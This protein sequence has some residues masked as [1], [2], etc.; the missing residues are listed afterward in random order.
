MEWVNERENEKQ[1]KMIWIYISWNEIKLNGMQPEEKKMKKASLKFK[2]KTKKKWMPSKLKMDSDL[3]SI[4]FFFFGV[5]FVIS[6]F[7]CECEI[8]VEVLKPLPPLEPPHIY[9]DTCQIW[10]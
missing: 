3:V 1:K 8:K 4:I 9:H 5:L 7:I 6:S 2:T 10:F